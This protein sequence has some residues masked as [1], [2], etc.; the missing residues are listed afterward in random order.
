MCPRNGFEPFSHKNCVWEGLL[1]PN[2]LWTW[3]KLRHIFP[4]TTAVLGNK[5]K[6][7]LK[8]SWRG[9]CFERRMNGLQDLRPIQNL[10]WEDRCY[11]WVEPFPFH[12]LVS[13][14]VKTWELQKE[15]KFVNLLTKQLFSTYFFDNLRFLAMWPE[16]ILFLD[17]LLIIASYGPLNDRFLFG[18]LFDPISKK[19]N[20]CFHPNCGLGHLQDIKL[21]MVLNF[22]INRWIF[23]IFLLQDHLIPKN[24]L[25]N[26]L[27]LKD[28]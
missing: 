3:L 21:S 9:L 2:I 11:V 27:N 17:I 4:I 8:Q 20:G 22:N 18:Y 14:S 19:A 24:I 26:I 16:N 1:T 23:R 7:S 15:S 12:C 6:I 28:L 25:K 13:Y 5:S 10:Y